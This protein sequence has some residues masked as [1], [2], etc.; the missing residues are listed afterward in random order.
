MGG[1]SEGWGLAEFGKRVSG[2]EGLQC[3][4]GPRA[5]V[6]REGKMRIFTV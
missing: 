1:C 6:V 2:I 3:R 5:L 4:D